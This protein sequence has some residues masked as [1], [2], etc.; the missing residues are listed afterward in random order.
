MTCG[1]AVD[2][3]G[4][5]H[6]LDTKVRLAPPGRPAGRGP[7]RPR[8]RP[9]QHARIVLS[10][11]V[12]ID[13]QRDAV[14]VD[15][16]A[17]AAFLP[18]PCWPRCAAGPDRHARG[19]AAR[20]RRAARGDEE[21]AM[22]SRRQAEAVEL[23]RHVV[24]GANYRHRPHGII[25]LGARHRGVAR[26]APGRDQHDVE[27]QHQPGELPAGARKCSAARAMR[28]RWRGAIASAGLDRGRPRLDLDRG[29][30]RRRA[31]R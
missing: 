1:H 27:A 16:P 15:R 18:A 31:G 13:G 12:G 30:G 28:R 22:P 4:K 14:V 19:R 5:A 7:R 25:A 3:P 29:R 8:H 23:D 26:Q 20:R 6:G 2:L 17:Q 21:E 9:W 24:V 11:V 10:Q